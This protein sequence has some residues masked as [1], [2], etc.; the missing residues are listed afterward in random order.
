[1]S[2]TNVVVKLNETHRKEMMPGDLHVPFK[3]QLPGGLF[4]AFSSMIRKEK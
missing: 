4:V 1:M 3:N 2:G